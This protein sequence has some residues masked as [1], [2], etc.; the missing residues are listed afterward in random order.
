MGGILRSR[1]MHGRNV[2]CHLCCCTWLYN[3][4]RHIMAHQWVHGTPGS[5]L[6]TSLCNMLHKCKYSL[7]S[8][9]SP[10]Q[11]I[12]AWNLLHVQHTNHAWHRTL[13]CHS[14]MSC[15]TVS[16]SCTLQH[17]PWI[18]SSSLPLTVKVEAKYDI[19]I[20][21][22]TWQFSLPIY[23]PITFLTFL[24]SAWWKHMTSLWNV[25]CI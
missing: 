3:L 1:S 12:L 2:N 15:A 16:T 8:R 23:C 10:S 14:S 24:S 22:L 9:T 20:Q 19:L 25:S 18:S 5:F 17:G 13:E 6:H 21:I 11:K 7:D 4:C